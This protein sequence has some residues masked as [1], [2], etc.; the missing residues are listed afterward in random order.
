MKN[1]FSQLIKSKL[2]L[3]ALL[4]LMCFGLGELVERAAQ[5]NLEIVESQ[6]ALEKQLHETEE[7]V[8]S[9][10]TNS[11]FLV[12]AI[13]GY[14]LE[15]TIQKYIDKPYTIIIYDDNDSIVYWN[16]N[17]TLPLKSHIQYT[18]E[19]EDKKYELGE[20]IYLK[21]IRP[22]EFRINGKIYY[23]NLVALIPIYKHYSI[24]NNYLQDYFP[25]MPA[26]FSQQTSISKESNEYV[27]KDKA[28]NTLL[29]VQAEQNSP[30]PWY[31]L[32]AGLLYLLGSISL[33]LLLYLLSSEI[34]KRKHLFAALGTFVFGIAFFR[35]LA[36]FYD[37]PRLAYDYRIFNYRVS[38]TNNTWFYSLGDF[39][40]DMSLLLLTAIF[41]GRELKK[42]YRIPNEKNRQ[43][44]FIVLNFMVVL[45]GISFIQFAIR[46][47]VSSSYLSFNFDN[48]TQIESFTFW[49]L[50]GIGMLTIAQ[51]FLA[52]YSTIAT[53]TFQVSPSERVIS[54]GGVTLVVVVFITYLNFPP[55]DIII[56][57]V[58][59]LSQLLLLYKYVQNKATSLAWVSIWILF[60]A[61]LLTLITENANAD[62]KIKLRKDYAKELAFEREITTENNFDILAP[63]IMSDGLLKISLNNPLSPS[64]RR[65]AVDLITYRYLDNYFFGKYDYSVHIYT[66]RNTPYKGEKRDYEE[67]KTLLL[68]ATP[69]S[70]EFLK[71]YSNPSGNFSYIAKIPLYQGNSLLSYIVIE[72]TPKKDFQ[73]SNIYV[74]LLSRNKARLE[75]IFATY[76]Y[77]LYKFDTRVSTN[78]SIFKAELPYNFPKPKK[79]GYLIV[80]DPNDNEFDYLLYRDDF[81]PDNISIIQL[82]KFDIYKSLSVFA[83]LFCFGLFLLLAVQLINTLFRRLT[84]KELLHIKFESSLREQIQKGI[85]L[86]TLSSFIAIALITILYYRYDYMDY[87]KS[88]LLRKVTTT[89]KT[90]SWQINQGPDSTT[91]LPDAKEL[92]DIHKIDV[93]I[94]SLS[95]DLISSS[96]KVIFERHL[97][98]KKMNPAAFIKLK[99]E[100]QSKVIQS[101]IINEFEYLSAYVPLKDKEGNTIAFLNLPYDLASNSNLGSQDVIKFL[102]ALLNVYVLFLLLAGVAAFIIASSVTN[103][104]SVISEKLDKVQLGQKNEPIEWENEDEIGE[105]VERYNHM[106]KELE[107]NTKKLA[108]SQRESAWREMAKQVAHEIKNPLT[109]MKLNIQLLQRV[110]NSKPEKAQ[111]MVDRVSS[112]LIEQIDSLAHIASEF[113]NFAK[114]PIANNEQLH[115]NTLVSNAYE[116]FREEENI[117][118]SL[119]MTDKE[120]FVF[121]DK[122]QIMRVLNNLLKNAVQAIPEEQPGIIKI[123]LEATSTTA[124]VT[125]KDNGIGIPEEQADDIFVP[126]F[127]T[128]SSGTGIGLAMSQ[129]IVEMAKGKIY[130]ESEIGLGTDFIVEL[131]LIEVITN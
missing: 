17:K 110:V 112:A 116:L 86:V 79:G 20:S 58:F 6:I 95:G 71:F 109:P 45:G 61:S 53:K 13:E 72:L 85:L 83:Y 114:M 41:V 92:A 54:F 52:Y 18:T 25:L 67:I 126:N 50:L 47:I 30:R 35:L 78:G 24:T 74:E 21:K 113:S 5:S 99:Q 36:I 59:G 122:T 48:F 81:Q 107:E 97:I 115:L 117:Q 77:A 12:N 27:I 89:A 42:N 44:L 121:A 124:I 1:T 7:E 106:I 100:Q 2:S 129:K 101:E 38:D 39:L 98:S 111:K 37:F 64:P 70:S 127:T 68:Y 94:Y 96:E 51:F 104:L 91:I 16:N 49:A 29:Y 90:A 102:G 73:K 23:Y 103:P 82:P 15:D 62:K 31:I 63:Q 66:D 93:N 32:F 125:V 10:F 22:Y 9:L 84:Q 55:I 131:P 14:L 130:F 123:K 8:S 46:D 56:V 34:A 69:T 118:I 26:S 120:C 60:F 4:A 19:A 11:T 65:Q 76:T 43:L 87:H 80:Q 108:R 28:G 3:L 88:R 75:S 105:L 57:G 40:V 128:K 119:N 33:T